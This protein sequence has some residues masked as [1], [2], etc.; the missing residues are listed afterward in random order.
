MAGSLGEWLRCADGREHHFV[1]GR[2][3]CGSM[4][5]VVTPQPPRDPRHSGC[6]TK[7]F[8]CGLCVNLNLGRWIVAYPG[9]ITPPAPKENPPVNVVTC[10]KCGA[11]MMFV[12][13]AAGKTMPVDAD[14][15]VD[16]NVVI[17]NGV[18]SVLP[19][20]ELRDMRTAAY[21]LPRYKSHFATCPS[22]NSFRKG[23]R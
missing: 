17:E 18:A 10:S 1:D 23:K 7:R 8:R 11:R 16:G 5:R 3:L 15:V 12:K 9:P 21:L 4:S 13:T 6:A 2:P 14:P 22:A 19:A 20:A